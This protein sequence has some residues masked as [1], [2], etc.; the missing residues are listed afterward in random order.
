MPPKGPLRYRLRASAGNVRSP[1]DRPSQYGIHIAPAGKSLSLA[2]SI[3]HDSTVEF[4]PQI[5]VQK[6]DFGDSDSETVARGTSA[7]LSGFLVRSELGAEKV[8]LR[9]AELF[10]L[11]GASWTA[12]QRD[13]ITA[14]LGRNTAPGGLR[15][16][17]V[18]LSKLRLKAEIYG[19]AVSVAY[20]PAGVER[21]GMPSKLE[22]IAANHRVKLIWAA[23]VFA[24]GLLLG[25]GRWFSK[26]S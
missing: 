22:W 3:V 25:F 14:L 15:I 9:R 8:T 7:I 26:S 5:P 11:T 20:G 19:Q 2:F 24:S 23:I 6:I 1:I 18:S 17:R 10:R 16:R 21:D 13:R 4:L 12:A